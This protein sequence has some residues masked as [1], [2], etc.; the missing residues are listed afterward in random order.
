LQFRI[1]F[2]HNHWR[3]RSDRAAILLGIYEAEVLNSLVNLPKINYTFLNKIMIKKL[4][5]CFLISL[6]LITLGEDKFSG[7]YVGAQLGYSYAKDKGKEYADGGSSTDWTQSASMNGQ[8][9]GIAAGF[10]KVFTNNF[11][12]GVESD[13]EVK[14]VDGKTFQRN[15]SGDITEYQIKTKINQA[16]SLRV[17]S[18]YLFN[19]STLAYITGG[20]ALGKVKRK[21]TYIDDDNDDGITE[22]GYGA[23]ESKS[24]WQSGWTA[25]LGIEKSFL[26][27]FSARLEYRYTD[28]GNK[29]FST[30]SVEDSTY[31]EKQKLNEDSLR[32]SLLYHF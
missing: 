5:L 10:N 13:F 11:L 30:G 29:N 31:I 8:A 24:S 1:K 15:K 9:L 27:K 3:G 25:G 7:P 17:R 18:G 6:P 22:F 4:T 20:Y 26:D 28:Y 32:L 19:E 21:I 2:T 14:N 16:F 23:S 12:L